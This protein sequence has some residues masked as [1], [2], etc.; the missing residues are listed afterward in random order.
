MSSDFSRP[1]PSAVSALA[2]LLL[3]ASLRKAPS[4]SGPNRWPT[5]ATPSQAH[6]RSR[7]LWRHAGLG[8]IDT[9]YAAEVPPTAS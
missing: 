5:E 9:E 8:K 1:F 7:D 4:K 3:C 2:F 6:T